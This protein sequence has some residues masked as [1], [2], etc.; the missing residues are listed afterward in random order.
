M[1]A[2]TRGDAECVEDE[3]PYPLMTCRLKSLDRGHHTNGRSLLLPVLEG[4]K[5]SYLKQLISKIIK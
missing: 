5:V 4:C 3:Y 2:R 1:N